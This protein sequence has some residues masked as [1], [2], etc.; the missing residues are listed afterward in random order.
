MAPRRR[1]S[2]KTGKIV[3]LTG[4]GRTEAVR[5]SKVTAAQHRMATGHYDRLEVRHRLVDAVLR[6]LRRG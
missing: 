1:K 5:W 6:A 3:P 4:A 2:R